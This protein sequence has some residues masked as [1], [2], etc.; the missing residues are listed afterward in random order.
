MAKLLEDPCRDAPVVVVSVARGES[1]EEVNRRAVPAAR[2]LAGVAAVWVLAPGGEEAF[3][4][5]L[6]KSLAVWGGAARC[7]LPGLD[8]SRAQPWRH[9]YLPPALAGAHPEAVAR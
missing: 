4:A 9:R 3:K 6:G 1:E 8:A 2:R 5:A 7:Y